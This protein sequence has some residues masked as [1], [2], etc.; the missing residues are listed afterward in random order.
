ML[1][2]ALLL[3]LATFYFAVGVFIWGGTF[4]LR[5]G[6]ARRRPKLTALVAV[7]NEAEN[8]RPCLDALLRQTYPRELYVWS[9]WTTALRTGRGRFFRS[10][11]KDIGTSR[12]CA[13]GDH[14]RDLQGSRGPWRWG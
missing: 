13:P 10:T 11:Q 7:R 4:R 8:I 1:L 6:R 2:T 5:K 9:W 3:F 14:P 12:S